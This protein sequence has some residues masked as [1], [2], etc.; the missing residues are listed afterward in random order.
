MAQ[1]VLEI[2][3]NTE[4]VKKALEGNIDNALFIAGL[5][6]QKDVVNFIVEDRVIDTGRLKSSI[7]FVTPTRIGVGKA[8]WNSRSGDQLSGKALP[9]SV[10][11][12]T[13]VDYAVYVNNGTSRQRARHFLETGIYR[14]LPRLKP[15]IER[16]LKG[17]SIN[18]S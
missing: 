2:T 3:D 5:E 1:I 4:L 12:G 7:S 17:D 9:N 10:E 16:V 14:A 8:S 6:V 18:V 11:I 15:I 13:N